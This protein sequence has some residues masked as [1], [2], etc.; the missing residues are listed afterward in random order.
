MKQ[1]KSQST[2][3]VPKNKRKNHTKI[4]KIFRKKITLKT[5]E[6]K[7]KKVKIVEVVVVKETKRRR[8]KS[9]GIIYF[10]QDT[11]D[12]IIEY[13]KTEEIERREELYNTRI[14]YP[15]DKLVENIFNTFKFSYFETGPIEVQRETVAHLVANMHKFQS[16]K[17]KAFAYFS[18]IAKH[19]LIAL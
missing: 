5:F 6:P 14:K 3:R 1:K 8:K 13:N 10:S 9:A 2:I 12:A 18:I 4:K 7:R 15:F 17:G 19:Y 11:E 16:D